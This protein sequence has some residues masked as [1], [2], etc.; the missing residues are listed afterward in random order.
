MNGYSRKDE[1]NLPKFGNHRQARLY[2]KN[3]HGDQFFLVDSD[4]IDGEKVYFY[5]LILNPEVY[6]K[7]MSALIHKGHYSGFDFIESYQRIE[8]WESGQVHMIH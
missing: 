1:N 3:K 4:S 6:E 5:N 7:G 2:F 8:I